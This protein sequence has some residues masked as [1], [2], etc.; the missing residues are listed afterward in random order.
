M[1]ALYTLNRYDESIKCFDNA[2]EINLL[3]Q[4]LKN[5]R[6]I[7]QKKVLDHGNNIAFKIPFFGSVR[8]S[9]AKYMIFYNATDL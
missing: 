8:I 1:F 5:I 4:K 7:T 6:I 9:K 3:I 2:L